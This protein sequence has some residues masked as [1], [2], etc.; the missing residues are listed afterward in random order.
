LR[1]TIDVFNPSDELGLRYAS[2]SD[3][4]MA[5]LFGSDGVQPAPTLSK[6][7]SFYQTLVDL[8][9]ILNPRAL[10]ATRSL[11][12][13]MF[14]FNEG[15]LALTVTPWELL[16][17]LTV[18]ARADIRASEGE[19]ARA[20]AVMRPWTRDRV[21]LQLDPRFAPEFRPDRSRAAARLVR[22]V[23]ADEILEGAYP[24]EFLKA[25]LD[26]SAPVSHIWPTPVRGDGTATS[27]IELV[28]SE[29][30][31]LIRQGLYQMQ[32]ASALQDRGDEVRAL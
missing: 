13:V 7:E 9:D 21:L 17:P 20:F 2:S 30:V 24:R 18:V 1:F 16:H 8:D 15:R 10:V 19:L 23:A 27:S 5:L 14:A 22:R 12:G 31:D 6:E 4:V 11:A 29:R 32:A 26:R 25:G 28:S 3:C